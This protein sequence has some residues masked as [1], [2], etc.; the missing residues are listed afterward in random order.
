MSRIRPAECVLN[1][2][3]IL[4]EH[5]TGVHQLP[6]LVSRRAADA[7]I[8]VVTPKR[9]GRLATNLWEQV[10]LPWRARSAVLISLANSGPVIDLDQ[11][12]AVSWAAIEYAAY[13]PDGYPQDIRDEVTERWEGMNDA[14]R[15]GVRNRVINRYEIE[16]Q[17]FVEEV[18]TFVMEEGFW[19]SFGPV[20]IVFFLLAIVTAFGVAFKDF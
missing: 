15:L 18:E 1:G 4:D 3:G 16:A 20:D 13:W 12:H 11:P 17:E 5:P 10:V 2:R 19:M 8:R 7:G 14:G 9:T 6:F